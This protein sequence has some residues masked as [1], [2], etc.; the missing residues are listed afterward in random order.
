M[1]RYRALQ[2]KLLL[3]QSPQNATQ[4]INCTFKVT[5]P[6]CKAH[7]KHKSQFRARSANAS[8]LL[9]EVMLANYGRWYS[10]SA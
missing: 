5:A 4:H 8:L 3:R 9:A 7:R 2:S 1:H 10:L 6:L